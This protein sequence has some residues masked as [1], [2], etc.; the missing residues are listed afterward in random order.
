MHLSKHSKKLSILQNKRLVLPIIVFFLIWTVPDILN[1][2]NGGLDPSWI[3]AI[4]L[5]K[6]TEFTWGSE[7]VWT[8]GI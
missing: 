6:L 7:I 1:Q 3:L 2:V 8:Y 4:H 5:A